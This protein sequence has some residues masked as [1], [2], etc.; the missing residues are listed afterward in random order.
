MN[1]DVSPGAAANTDDL[2]GAAI[3]PGT[4]K[5]KCSNSVSEGHDRSQCKRNASRDRPKSDRHP[6]DWS[7]CSEVMGEE[8]GTDRSQIPTFQ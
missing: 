3:I 4:V 7:Q 1:G 5:S 2:P 8:V 6:H